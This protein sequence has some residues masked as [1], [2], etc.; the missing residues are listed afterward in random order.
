[1]LEENLTSRDSDLVQVR[2]ALVVGLADLVAHRDVETVSH[3]VRL[4]R[5]CRILAEEACRCPSFAG[6]I[7]GNFIQMLEC[8]AP[9]HDIGKAGLPDAILTKT[10]NLD[11]EER[12]AMQHHTLIGAE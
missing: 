1:Q 7:D 5:Y 11:A 12:L 3:A 6:Q 10:G 4:Q 2:N 9:L 8:C